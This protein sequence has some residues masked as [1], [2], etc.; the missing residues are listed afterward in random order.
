MGSIKM[1]RK[2]VLSNFVYSMYKQQAT[3]FKS[4]KNTDELVQKFKPD[5]VQW[6][7]LVSFAANDSIKLDNVNPKE[8]AQLLQH[9]QA[10]MARQL[11]RNEGYFEVMNR[12]DEALQKAL[13]SL[14]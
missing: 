13:G 7:Q 10:L 12:Y 9:V 3:S 2:N 14:K 8:K 11:F 5:D 4:I 1:Y 6:H